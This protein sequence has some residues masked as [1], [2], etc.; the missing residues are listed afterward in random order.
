[1]TPA[2]ARS[3]LRATGSPQQ[4]E[5]GRPATQ[6]IGS[7]PDLRAL[8]AA[9]VK[10]F[11]GVDKPIIKVPGCPPIAEV[12]TGVITYYVTFGE[13]PALD[14]RVLDKVVALLDRDRSIR[15]CMNLDPTSFEDDALLGAEQGGD[16]DVAYVLRDRDRRHVRRR[17]RSEAEVYTEQLHRCQHALDAF[18]D[19]LHAQV[20][21]AFGEAEWPAMYQIIKRE[22]GFNPNSYN[23][24]SGA[25]GL[26]QAEILSRYC[27]AIPSFSAKYNPCP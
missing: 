17:Q 12:M 22:S 6:R 9:H 13:L 7:R 5:P 16:D 18:G 2:T 24:R 21:A 20:V 10:G 25:C 1:M 19:H 15:I 11:T 23:T 8:I 26:F 4:D 3:W 27:L 14:R